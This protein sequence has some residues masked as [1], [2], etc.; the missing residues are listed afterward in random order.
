MVFQSRVIL[1]GLIKAEYD[2]PDLRLQRSNV[3]ERLPRAY[4]V[5]QRREW[6]SHPMSRMATR[7]SATL[8]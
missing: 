7:F 6:A 4:F 8:L 5:D 1:L 2:K 3:S